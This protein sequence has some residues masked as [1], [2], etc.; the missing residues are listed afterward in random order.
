MLTSK[1]MLLKDAKTKGYHPEILE[2]VY[3]L[4]GCIRKYY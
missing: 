4:L 1:E 2:K 3:R